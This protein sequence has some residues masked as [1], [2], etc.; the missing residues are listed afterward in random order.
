M[1]YNK[2]VDS[3]NNN[4]SRDFWR[5]IGIIGVASDRSHRVPMQVK[6]DNGYLVVETKAVLYSGKS[7]FE[8]LYSAQNNDTYDD[9][10]LR[11]V[12]VR[13][14]DN[15]DQSIFTFYSVMALRISMIRLLYL[16]NGPVAPLRNK[17]IM[18]QS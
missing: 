9:V 6:D 7:D 5:Q 12:R 15:N 18:I 14:S 10:H 17:P 13:P 3:F 16:Y 2:L 11:D 1:K 8:N 4:D